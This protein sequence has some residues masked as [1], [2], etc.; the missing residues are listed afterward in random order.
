MKKLSVLF[1]AMLMIIGIA[2]TA[3]AQPPP[4]GCVLDNYPGG[5]S[6]H[7]EGG[8]NVDMTSRS[9]TW[10][11]VLADWFPECVDGWKTVEAGI[12]VHISENYNGEPFLP[13]QFKI[14]IEGEYEAILDIRPDG[15]WYPPPPPGI[16]PAYIFS[17]SPNHET[18][19]VVTEG[20][21]DG[22]VEVTIT[23]LQNDD[24]SW[25][26]FHIFD[27]GLRPT[28]VETVEEETVV[29]DEEKAKA[30]LV[31]GAQPSDTVRRLLNK[32]RVLE[33]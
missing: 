2:A 14:N 8:V 16:L 15:E 12:G 26:A 21:Q 10:T 3:S 22:E 30:W 29:I 13:G 25:P 23:I 9:H 7:P 27:I 17:P 11:F 5:L 18:T 32:T 20:F 31:K 4:M 24:G 6:W 33:K 1:C 19:D 28:M